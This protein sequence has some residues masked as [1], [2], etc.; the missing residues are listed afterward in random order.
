[1]TLV[2]KLNRSLVNGKI[3]V[4][5]FLD[6]EKAFDMIDHKFFLAK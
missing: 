4:G 3:I 2:K 6:L 5:D 1:M